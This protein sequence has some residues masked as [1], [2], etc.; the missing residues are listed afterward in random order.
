MQEADWGPGGKD[1]AVLRQTQASHWVIEYPVGHPLLDTVQPV[2]GMRLSP[3]GSTLAVMEGRN[4]LLVDRAGGKKSLGEVSLFQGLAWSASGAEIQFACEEPTGDTGLWTIT[5]SGKRRLVYRAAGTIRLHDLSP[6]GDLLGFV[7]LHREVMARA[8]GESKEQD[9]SWLDGSVAVDLSSDGKTLL[10]NEHGVA[11]GAAGAYYLR[12]T[13][14][15]PPVKLGEGQAY[16]LSWDGKLVLAGSAVKSGA[17]SL[18]IV[19]TGAGRSSPVPLKGLDRLLDAWFFP[20]GK[21]LLLHGA[22]PGREE[23]FFTVGL[24]GGTPSPL[25]PE[26]TTYFDGQKPISPDGRTVCCVS[27]MLGDLKAMLY[28]VEGGTPRLLP[29]YEQGDIIADWSGDGRYLFVFRRDQIPAPV[30]RIEVSTGKREP[31]RELVPSNTTGTLGISRV[32]VTPDGATVAYSYIRHLEDLYWV[33]G[34][35]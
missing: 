6:A 3:D 17:L 15:S 28:P 9:L 31:W 30:V 1:M 32:L 25:T 13:D 8:P 10:L 34:L 23:R 20:E 7:S 26:G 18:S 2:T 14:G 12:H 5:P 4:L 11:A 19:P 22:L 21:R 35:K 24:E 33:K 29:G 27:G 16:D